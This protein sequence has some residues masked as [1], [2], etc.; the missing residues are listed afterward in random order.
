MSITI[1]N[2]EDFEQL[3]PEDVRI[4]TRRYG[5]MRLLEKKRIAFSSQGGADVSLL[6]TGHVWA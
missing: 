5:Y 1:P 2:D 4:P 3:D 6:V